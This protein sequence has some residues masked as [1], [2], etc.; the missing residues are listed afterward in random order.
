MSVGILGR[1]IASP[2]T[3]P[4]DFGGFKGT[5]A[6]APTTAAGVDTKAARDAAI[7]AAIAGL[8]PGGG[9]YTELAAIDLVANAPDF[10]FAAIVG[11]Y[12]HLELVWWGRGTKVA[13]FDT[14][15]LQFNG[16]AGANYEWAIAD[17]GSLFNNGAGQASALAGDVTG[18][19][20]AAGSASGGRL[21]L[22]FYADPTFA[23]VFNASGYMRYSSTYSWV[24]GGA[25]NVAAAIARVR[26]F[27]AGGNWLAGSRAALYG[28]A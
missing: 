3:A 19:N 23:K 7:A 15:R 1:G 20:I 11:T 4:L 16:D 8:P 28:I 2:L 21:L 12:R 5:N 14:V 17:S 27:P 9:S 6:A 10:D 24:G 18:A 26:L 22:P 13:D 25:W